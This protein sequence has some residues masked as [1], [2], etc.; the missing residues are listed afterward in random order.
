MRRFLWVACCLV[1]LTA[2]TAESGSRAS[3]ESKLSAAQ[4]IA[5]NVQARGGLKAWR[6]V[7][8]LTMSGA[9]D[10]GSAKNP[11]L[12]FVMKMKRQHKSRLEIRFKDQTAIQVYDGNQ[13]W[14]VRPFLGRDEVEPF[15]P[16]EAR[17]AADWQE[18]DG[19]L[20]DY[21]KKG[22]TAELQGRETVD[23]HK[24][25]KLK[26]TMK[27]GSERHV[28]IDA[29]NFLE[30]KIDGEPRIMDGKL[31][32]VTV[33]YREYRKEKGLMMPHVFE[34]AVEGGTKVHRMHI[35]EVVVNAPMAD[36][37]F[38]K[39]QMGAAVRSAYTQE[40]R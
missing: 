18:L 32:H 30:L 40:A 21:A 24:A 29:A 13:G 39:P 15:T 5:K 26:L 23:G 19:P 7:E 36:T 12:P 17:E 9:L 34:T 25:Y 1:P 33:F 20:M 3:H 6:A 31:R 38:A 14:K 10:G 11:E 2:W 4:V 37:L 35:K 27:D 8:T 28:W 22:T 16:G